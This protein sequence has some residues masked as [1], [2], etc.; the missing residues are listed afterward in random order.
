MI[1]V[2]CFVRCSCW[3][4]DNRNDPRRLRCPVS[5][6]ASRFVRV[7][8]HPTIP[9][10]DTVA[11]YFTS[12]SLLHSARLHGRAISAASRRAPSRASRHRAR[13]GRAAPHRRDRARQRRTV[14]TDGGTSGEGMEQ[15]ETGVR[16]HVSREHARSG[17]RWSQPLVES[18]ESIAD[19]DRSLLC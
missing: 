16:I 14:A 13:S 1:S 3:C 5:R 9:R 4:D 6:I 15:V 10:H 8:I 2:P 11:A 12:P 7:R 18:A 19:A 17:R